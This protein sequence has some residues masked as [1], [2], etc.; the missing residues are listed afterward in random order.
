LENVGSAGA[1]EQARE[2]RDHRR[3]HREVDAEAIEGPAW[4]AEVALHVDHDQRGVLG[5]DE[6]LELGEHILPLDLDHRQG[7]NYDMEGSMTT[8]SESAPLRTQLET[9]SPS[10][11]VRS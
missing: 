5:I 11:P 4:R 6:F 1:L 10:R 9:S 8:A 2:P 3:V 7:E